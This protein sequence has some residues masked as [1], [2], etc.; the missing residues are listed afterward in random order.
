MAR[1]GTT[2]LNLGT[3]TDG[4][5]PG[6][7]SQTIDNTGLNGNFIKL[8]TAI[9]T[10]HTTAGAHKEDSI[11]KAAL[12]SDVVDGSTLEKDAVN[13]YLKV[14]ALGITAAQ[15]ATDAV[16]TAKIKDA[17][18][19]AAKLA[20][21]SVETAKIKDANVTAAKLVDASITVTK[22]AA[23]VP[24]KYLLYSEHRVAAI[25]AGATPAAASEW[26]E[27]ATS[28]V[29]K[30]AVHFVKRSTSK[31]LRI[32]CDVTVSTSLPPNGEI[33][34]IQIECDGATATK[35]N[36]GGVSNFITTALDISGL[37]T[38][39]I[40]EAKVNMYVNVATTTIKMRKPTLILTDD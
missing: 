3:W 28:P 11:H 33:G 36:P 6:A 26:T 24:S 13:E 8:D 16:E 18:V 27:T 17:N 20:T 39:R 40:Y 14:K 38:D 30:I 23:G 21:D 10:G 12:H 7:G 37:I 35:S 5:N 32:F 4:E 19:T 29:N 1:V 15:I 9:G 31:Y 25:T 2:N 22:L 34:Y